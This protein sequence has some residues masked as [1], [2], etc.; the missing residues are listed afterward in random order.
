MKKEETHREVYINH[1][2]DLNQ[3][4]I[5]TTILTMLKIMFPKYF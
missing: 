5:E 1:E 4:S 2:L 3:L